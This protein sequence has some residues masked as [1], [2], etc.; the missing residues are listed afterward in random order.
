MKIKITLIIILFSIVK[1]NWSQDQYIGKTSQE[2]LEFCKYWE[3]EKDIGLFHE[4]Y[5]N[6]E[7]NEVNLMFSNTS[8]FDF[9]FIASRSIIFSIKEGICNKITI[10]YL[11]MSKSKLKTYYLANNSEFNNISNYFF[12]PNYQTYRILSEDI[13]GDAVVEVRKTE[14]RKLSSGVRTKVSSGLNAYAQKQEKEKREEAERIAKNERARAA[15]IAKQKADRSERLSKV[16]YLDKDSK[17]EFNLFIKK[18]SENFIREFKSQE[19]SITKFCMSNRN[20]ASFFEYNNVYSA[21][22]KRQHDGS[23]NDSESAFITHNEFKLVSGINKSLSIINEV[24]FDTPL[25]YKDNFYWNTQ[26]ILEKIKTTVVHGDADVK[27]KNGKCVFVKGMSPEYLNELLIE[28][29]TET[30]QANGKYTLSYYYIK[31]LDIETVE[32]KLKK[33]KSALDIAKELY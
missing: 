32:I 24:A 3:Q 8:D 15:E 17:E 28:K 19:K 13:L 18:L 1:I 20:E 22:F 27:V 14:V 9:D 5:K 26:L 29:I 7:L 21:K 23:L 16:L 10:E 33:K 30:N 12:A 2:V 25:I 6:G 31:A 11:E 4:S